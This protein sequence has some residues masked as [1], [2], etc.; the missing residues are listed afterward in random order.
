M[1]VTLK[2]IPTWMV[3][4]SAPA[5]SPA[6]VQ[7]STP[8]PS[9]LTEVIVDFLS[10]CRQMPGY[11][12]RYAAMVSSRILSSYQFFHHIRCYLR[13]TVDKCRKTARK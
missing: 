1:Y 4:W 2:T 11:S 12:F 9:I 5:A 3:A 6:P 7:I 8:L 10:L 13:V